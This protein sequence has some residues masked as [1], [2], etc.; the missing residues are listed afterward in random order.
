M[1]KM[2]MAM[3]VLVTM[4]INALTYLPIG[5]VEANEES[6]KKYSTEL[7][8]VQSE[9]AD[10]YLDAKSISE[11]TNAP[12]GFILDNKYELGDVVEVTY[13]NDDIKSER[14]ITGEELK[15]LEKEMAEEINAVYEE[16]ISMDQVDGYV[17]AEDGS[18]VK[19][20]FYDG[21]IQAEDGSYVKESF[22]E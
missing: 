15:E 21:Y 22:Y 9:T 8:V 16:G 19:E 6:E 1:K 4:G 12:Y 5:H 20:S 11:E 14:V 7:F 13:W 10:G 18:Y 17:Q 2:I 3:A